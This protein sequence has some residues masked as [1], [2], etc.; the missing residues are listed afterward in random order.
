LEE[1]W[2]SLKRN[3]LFAAL[4]DYPPW[5][6]RSSENA[7]GKPVSVTPLGSPLGNPLGLPYW[8]PAWGTPLAGAHMGDRP[9]EIRFVRSHWWPPLGKPHFGNPL[10][11]K[12]WGAL[13]DST[14][15]TPFGGNHVATHWDRRMGTPCGK[16]NW[17]PPW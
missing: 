2:S 8:G 15:E 17:G 6:D 13:G 16:R 7:K 1:A 12:P 4:L 14:L 9:W 10:E 5:G 11:E 3:A